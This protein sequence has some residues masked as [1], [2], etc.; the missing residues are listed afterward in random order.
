MHS[1]NT[2]DYLEFSSI[3]SV[4][5]YPSSFRLL[6]PRIQLADK[7]DQLYWV[8]EPTIAF[9]KWP[10]QKW[11]IPRDIHF[12]INAALILHP[13]YF[14]YAW[15]LFWDHCLVISTVKLITEHHELILSEIHSFFSSFFL[16]F[17]VSLLY[18]TH[19]LLCSNHNEKQKN[20]QT[21]VYTIMRFDW[22]FKNIF[23]NL[24]VHIFNIFFYSN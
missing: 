15:N 7:P 10:N 6:K 3:V 22:V 1:K 9:T 19:N 23:L 12:Y 20:K 11:W 18:F 5:A 14:F 21:I 17:F 2:A 8:L 13:A 4:L 24:F 16:S